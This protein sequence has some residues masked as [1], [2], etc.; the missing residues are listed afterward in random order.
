[1]PNIH[2]RNT[3]VGQ[4]AT[5]LET[6]TKAND[7]SRNVNRVFTTPP[8]TI[9]T[10]TPAVVITQ[11]TETATDYIG[12]IV[13]RSLLVNLSFVDSYAGDDADGEA[14][15]F[16]A[17]IQTAMGSILSLTVSGTRSSGGS[18]S[19]SVRI[20]EDGNSLNFGDPIRGKIYGVASY[21][22]IYRT[23]AADP[24]LLP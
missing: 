5:Q 19:I 14:L 20:E 8:N 7:Y 12:S 22:I 10:P 17:D 24:G 15:E 18:G 2:L 4:V 23:S 21:R 16:L 9:N 13:E 11:G 6:I 3:I 1:M